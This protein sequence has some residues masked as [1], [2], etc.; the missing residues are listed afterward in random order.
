MYLFLFSDFFLYADGSEALGPRAP[1]VFCFCFLPPTYPLGSSGPRTDREIKNTRPCRTPPLLGASGDY[2]FGLFFFARA[3]P[4][5][6]GGGGPRRG[7][8]DVQR[9]RQM[10]VAIHPDFPWH[11]RIAVA[12]FA[13]IRGRWWC[14][15]VV[16]HDWTGEV[17]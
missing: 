16:P 14:G 17:E 11:W 4:P 5:A 15:V 7:P 3:P 9:K 2:D 1:S 12:R 10:E 8:L 6:R 13:S